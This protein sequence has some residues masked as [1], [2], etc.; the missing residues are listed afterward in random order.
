MNTLE[1]LLKMKVRT[2][3][4]VEF[5]PDFRLSVQSGSKDGIHVIIHP[6]GHDGKTLDF[7]VKNNKL[8]PK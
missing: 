8:I 6:F 2:R 4:N 7:I 5:T 1:S 3:N